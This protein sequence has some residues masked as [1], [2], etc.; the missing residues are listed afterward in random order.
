MIKSLDSEP[1]RGLPDRGRRPDRARAGGD[2]PARSWTTIA[3]EVPEYA[4]PLEGRFGRGIRTGVGEAL[5]QFVALIRDPEAGRGL[6]REVYVGARPRRAAPGPHARLAAG[7]LPGRRAGRLAPH[8]RARAARARLDS[9]VLSL[10]AEA[11][12]AYI[13]ELSADSVEGYAEAQSESR[14]PA[15]P[16]PA[17]AGLLL[18]REP[19]AAEPPTCA[20]PRRPPAGGCRAGSPPSPAPRRTWRGWR[21]ACRPMRSPPSS[22]GLGC[23]LVPDPTGRAAEPSSSVPP[24]ARGCALGPAVEP[25]QA[26]ES[27]R[28]AKTALA[29]G[30]GGRAAVEGPGSCRGAP[31]RP[32]ALRGQ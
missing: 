26:R 10:L 5:S 3:R 1:W 9:E 28:L 27:W 21:G 18:T 23:V 6:G 19:A 12:F 14:G 17:R 29:G 22:T 16:P 13:D 8:R 20:P 24:S 30:R 15:P 32:A 7:G 4:R 31:G 2:R 25:A 11:I